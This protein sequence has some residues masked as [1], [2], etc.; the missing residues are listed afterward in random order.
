MYNMKTP[1]STRGRLWSVAVAALLMAA[2]GCAS[3]GPREDRGD[4][5]LLTREQL[6]R[7]DHL[8]AFD[9]IRRFK[10]LWLRTERGQDSFVTQGRR[11]L[12]VYLDRVH[13]GG[14]ETLHD[15]DV[16]NIEEIRF[17]DKRKATIEFGTDHAEG[18]LLITTRS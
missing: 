9:A 15:I 2:S 16:R 4:R 1:D 3:T 5:D 11:G 13:Y 7:V 18:A 10:P 6:S 8:S 14:V 17:L 12:R